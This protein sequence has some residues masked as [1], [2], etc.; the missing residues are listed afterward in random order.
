[1][2]PYQTSQ[3]AA[4]RTMNDKQQLPRGRFAR[5]SLMHFSRGRPRQ[6]GAGELLATSAYGDMFGQHGNSSSSRAAPPNRSVQE[7]TLH[8]RA[9]LGRTW[10]T[11]TT[12]FNQS[13]APRLLHSESNLSSTARAANF[14][15]AQCLTQCEVLEQHAKTT[16][17]SFRPGMSGTRGSSK[18]FGETE[19]RAQAFAEDLDAVDTLLESITRRGKERPVTPRERKERLRR[20]AEARREAEMRAARKAEAEARDPHRKVAARLDN[21]R[22]F[23]PEEGHEKHVPMMKVSFGGH[24]GVEQVELVDVRLLRARMQQINESAHVDSLLEL[25]RHREKQG[26][27]TAAA[28]STLKSSSSAP[29]AVGNV[30]DGALRRISRDKQV[31][32]KRGTGARLQKET[33]YL[34]TMLR[35]LKAMRSKPPEATLR[36]LEATLDRNLEAKR[37]HVLAPF[38]GG[39]EHISELRET[40]NGERRDSEASNSFSSLK[41]SPT[42]D[43]E[44]G[45]SP[46]K[47]TSK[48]MMKRAKENRATR[49]RVQRRWLLARFAGSVFFLYRLMLRKRHASKIVVAFLR[50]L[51]EWSR[52]QHTMQGIIRNLK[53][54]QR[55]CR[56]FLATK[57]SRCEMMSKD[58]Q[59]IEDQHLAVTMQMF[60][61]QAL[62][63]QIKE[64]AVAK[65]G[66]GGQ[67]NKVAM[68]RAMARVESSPMIK[69]KQQAVDNIDWRQFRVP[70]KERMEMIAK[71]YMVRMRKRVNGTKN[72]LSVVQ[73]VVRSQRELVHF[74]QQFGAGEQQAAELSEL[75]IG[76]QLPL[77]QRE[78]WRL[79]E[80]TI[81]D[82]IALSVQPLRQ[83]TPF[84][85]HPAYRDHPHNPFWRP[86]LKVSAE[87]AARHPDDLSK[88][89][90]SD[91][92]AS[93]H[94]AQRRLSMPPRVAIKVTTSV[95]LDEVL[96]QFTPRLL[97]GQA[98]GRSISTGQAPASRMVTRDSTRNS[99]LSRQKFGDSMQN[100][101]PAGMGDSK[102]SF[103]RR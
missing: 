93:K 41:L 103:W 90:I 64:L 51:G 23:G 18:G 22:R 65:T 40:I 1:M 10:G 91:P 50:Q 79:S 101:R 77:P 69:L 67:Q 87:V 102:D 9:E 13:S 48:M 12:I 71:Y 84:Q 45:K 15:A 54:L 52:L 92:H 34:S 35:R 37:R 6:P 43:S 11:E 25:Q 80:D 95:D 94:D 58:W 4:R 68:K 38:L 7:L 42:A 74:L 21:T 32:E 29:A 97:Q 60:A 81:L 27:L 46:G 85:D 75:T 78:F 82:L 98:M 31:M 5:P 24:N 30:S 14:K 63:D 72:L 73:N 61:Q 88:V 8:P 47:A 19:Q 20:E 2:A 56:A 86:D 89:G 49:K 26:A 28:K 66:A 16:R 76:Y 99:L 44:G 57:R 36:T 83:T 100:F 59:R 39:S 96:G 55:S 53:I 70:R 62:Q 3:S 33:V 17:S